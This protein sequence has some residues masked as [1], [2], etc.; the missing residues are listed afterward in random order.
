LAQPCVALV[1]DRKGG[2]SEPRGLDKREDGPREGDADAAFRV[3]VDHDLCQGH[4]VCASEAPEVFSVSKKGDLTILD[5]TPP[6]DQLPKVEM[7]VKHCPTRAL[8]ITKKGD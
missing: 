4:A 8:S 7:A 5:P 3:A 6:A 1:R 2:S